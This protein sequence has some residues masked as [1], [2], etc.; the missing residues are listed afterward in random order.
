MINVSNKCTGCSACVLKCPKQ[1]IRL[2]CSRE[3]FLYPIIGQSECINCG[4]CEKVCP[5]ISKSE[6]IMKL[7]HL[8]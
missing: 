1:C 6:Y 7:K 3:G 5:V 4:I 8:Q 2:E